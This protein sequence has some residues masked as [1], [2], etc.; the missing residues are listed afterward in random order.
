M[1][2]IEIVRYHD[3]PNSE[4]MGRGSVLGNPIPIT[5]TTS[6]DY[7]CDQYEIYLYDKVKNH[8]ITVINELKR[9]HKKGTEQGY[10]KLG[11][12]CVPKRCHVESIRKFLIEDFDI[13]LNP[14]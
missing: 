13:F 1:F 6:R 8:N 10:L 2:D 14:I 7:V 9:L 3:E 5:T 4:Y 12:F 11:C